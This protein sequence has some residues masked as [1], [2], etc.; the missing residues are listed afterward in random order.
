M[1]AGGGGRQPP[2]EDIRVINRKEM[3][4]MLKGHRSGPPVLEEPSCNNP[5][6]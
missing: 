6:V 4:K 2:T 1:S 5:R 3:G